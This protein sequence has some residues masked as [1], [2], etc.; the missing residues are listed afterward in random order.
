MTL[1]GGYRVPINRKFLIQNFG[2][3]WPVHNRGFTALL[4]ECRRCF[5][6]DMDQLLILSVIGDRTLGMNRAKGLNYADFL[7]GKR[8]VGI[9][10]RINTQS[11]ADSTGIPRETVRRKIR[12]LIERGWVKKNEDGTL[13]VTES[14]AVDLAP[15]TQATFDYFLA[16]GNIL[17]S[18][19]T[20]AS[21]SRIKARGGETD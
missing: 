20:E 17:L 16:L 3:L 6:G 5:D 11:V 1:A 18:K 10:Q 15:A 8:A 9:P 7:E 14:A 12:R 13:E 4:I 21:A 2:D 19:A